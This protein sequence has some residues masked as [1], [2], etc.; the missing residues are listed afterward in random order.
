M[1]DGHVPSP[2]Y[3]DKFDAA[4]IETLSAKE[5]IEFI[6]LKS[7]VSELK[8]VIKKAQDDESNLF[9]RNF[10]LEYMD[11]FYEHLINLLNYKKS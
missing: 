4:K 3:I 11:F 7:L 5:Q 8:E 10:L 2:H 1:I 6:K 9:D